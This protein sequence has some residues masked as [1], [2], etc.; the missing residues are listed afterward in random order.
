MDELNPSVSVGNISNAQG[1][2][3]G[4][5]AISVVIK[6]IINQLPM[7]LT[8]YE[9][10]I[11]QI[12]KRDSINLN[13]PS[14]LPLTYYP[15]IRSN[16]GLS[17]TVTE[18]EIWISLINNVNQPIEILTIKP[19]ESIRSKG[20]KQYQVSEKRIIDP[21]GTLPAIR[22]VV[23]TNALA[24]TDLFLRPDINYRIGQEENIHTEVEPLHIEP[25]DAESLFAPL[26][27]RQD[28]LTQIEQYLNL[29]TLQQSPCRL[30]IADKWG[31]GRSRAIDECVRI[32]CRKGFSVI[33]GEG[34]LYTGISD[35]REPIREAIASILGL[36][37]DSLDEDLTRLTTWLENGAE[38]KHLGDN[39]I[40]LFAQY[41][42]EGVNEQ[43]NLNAVVT[44]ILQCA[45]SRPLLIAIDDLHNAP[46][47]TR[48][49]LRQLYDR[50]ANA[51]VATIAMFA[52][53]DPHFEH[54]SDKQW[55]QAVHNLFRDKT[56][57]LQELED[58]HVSE[59]VSNWFPELKYAPDQQEVLLRFLSKRP[60]L[61]RQS[62]KYLN[63][64]GYLY[65]LNGRWILRQG[66]NQD[67]K[68]KA[69]VYTGDSEGFDALLSE[70][71]QLLD[72]DQRWIAKGL[73][74]AVALGTEFE[75]EL[76]LK[77]MSRYPDSNVSK[78]I[79][80]I[81]ERLVRSEFIVPLPA[82]DENK[83]DYQITPAVLRQAIWQEIQ[84]DKALAR[85][86]HSLIVS[87]L[88]EQEPQTP[89]NSGRIAYHLLWSHDRSRMAEAFDRFSEAA[90]DRS[91]HK[92]LDEA[93]ALYSRAV[94]AAGE[95]RGA[96][97]LEQ[98]NEAKYDLAE[99]LDARGDR[100]YASK[101]A[102]EVVASCDDDAL[103]RLAIQAY[104][105]AG[106][107]FQ[108]MSNYGQAEQFY[109]QATR[110]LERVP[111]P[112]LEAR[113]Y[114]KRAALHV[115]QGEL[116]TALAQYVH[117]IQ[118]EQPIEDLVQCLGSYA[119]CLL[120]CT[121]TADACRVMDQALEKVALLRS[122]TGMETI[123]ARIYIQSAVLDNRLQNY[124]RSLERLESAL[125][126][127][128][129][130]GALTEWALAESW[131]GT[132]GASVEHP[133][134]SEDTLR[135]Y[136]Y[137][138]EL[139]ELL[140]DGDLLTEVLREY[141]PTLFAMKRYHEVVLSVERATWLGI[142]NDEI[143]KLG[144]AAVYELSRCTSR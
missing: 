102:Q 34:R 35:F 120:D 54:P 136:A 106:A 105:L 62:L 133:S 53:F 72:S 33:R 43:R 97:S 73:R 89:E 1:V 92:H 78:H 11:K 58:S 81:R 36:T 112:A 83:W 10:A 90:R 31:T 13:L 70:Y 3:I 12:R 80:D 87:V 118:F 121:Q 82:D 41:L 7:P 46:P 5:G 104:I 128:K 139:S 68:S 37:F 50:A 113:L 137:A 63:H 94:E 56:T 114:R 126:I 42:Y 9:T 129:S 22:Y 66:Y 15:R 48:E 142:H 60:L 95:S 75:Y 132:V 77:A 143:D 141:V 96:V 26:V 39:G 6:K 144:R 18:T 127:A 115:K 14:L 103:A 25:R 100:L 85:E 71:H 61:V 24:S 51:G 55:L 101:I 84:N 20:L 125:K 67:V 98:M 38:V 131:L 32:M 64:T 117:A 69:R 16:H 49:I 30:A 116:E 86:I 93:I 138:A 135:H 99:A 4:N 88:Q 21:F 109:S 108:E 111:A 65:L 23:D 17:S 107:I 130:V 44:G 47:V 134:F 119:M 27:D 45:R 52:T 74:L 59:M 19:P 124:E 110:L 122:T 140:E 8:Y 28:L 91:T 29:A 76:W 40:A 79:D 123:L 2:A 57:Y